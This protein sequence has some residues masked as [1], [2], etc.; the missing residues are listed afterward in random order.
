V[1]RVQQWRSE[2]PDFQVISQRYEQG[3]ILLTTNQPYIW[4]NR[5]ELSFG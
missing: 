4:Q 1:K 5:N 2:H 3:S